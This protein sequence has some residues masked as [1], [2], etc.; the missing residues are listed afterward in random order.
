MT[1]KIIFVKFSAKEN[2]EK[3]IIVYKKLK[4]FTRS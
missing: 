4:I 1:K 2:V 3:I